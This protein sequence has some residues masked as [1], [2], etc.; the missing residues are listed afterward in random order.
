[1][2]EAPVVAV[3]LADLS[4]DEYFGTTDVDL[5]GTFT[6]P[7]AGDVLTLSAV[8]G[9]PAVVTVSVTGATLTVTEVGLG[10]SSIIVTATDI[11]GLSIA[12]TFDIVVNNVNDAPVVAAQL[13]DLNLDEHFGT[14]D[15]DLTGV[16]SDQDTGDVLTL[17][18]VSGT[19]TVVTVSVTGTTLTVTEV[20]LGTSSIIVTATDIDGLSIADTF[21]ITVNNVNDAPVILVPLADHILDE[22]FGFITVDLAGT[23]SD[24]DAGDVLTLSAVSGNTSVVTVSLSGVIL[25]VTEA[26]LGSATITVTASDGTLEVFDQ[27]VV[28]VNNVNDSPVVSSP[29]D[30]QSL[31]EYFGSAT[32]DVSGVFVDPDIVDILSLS[33]SC[34]DTDVVDVSLDGNILTISEVGLG[35]ATITLTASDGA[36]S[37]DDLFDVTVYNVNDAPV[38]AGILSDIT[39]DQGFVSTTVDLTGIFTDKDGDELSIS[40]ESSNTDVVTVTVDGTILSI[41]EVSVGNSTITVSANDGLLG[42]STSFEITV[43]VSLPIDWAYAPANYS[44]NGQITAA[45]EINGTRVNSGYLAAFV[46]EECRGYV[47]ASYF[48]PADHYVFDLLCFSNASSDEYLHFRYYDYMTM[49]TYELYDTIQFTPDMITGNAITPEILHFYVPYT[50]TFTTGWN[51]FSIN[52]IRE[53]MSLAAIMPACVT[54]GDNIKNQTSTATYYEGYGWFGSLTELK[55]K[56]LYK[57]YIHTGCDISTAGNTVDLS[58]TE[59]PLVGG[60]NWIGYLPQS[61]MPI[62][63]ALGSLTLTQLDY[64]KSQ[65]STATYYNGFGWFGS[66]LTMDPGEGYMLKLANPDTLIYP[67]AASKKAQID[68]GTRAGDMP[69]PHNFEF[70][71]TVTA[72]VLMEGLDAGSEENILYAYVG[73]E[74]RGMAEGLY[75]EPTGEFL[76]TL[77]IYSNISEGEEITFRFYDGVKGELHSCFEKLVFSSDMV[78]ADAYNTF[79]VN[80]GDPLGLETDNIDGLSLS[81]YP[82]PSE[83]RVWIDFS[84]PSETAVTI[85]IYDITGKMLEVLE[86]GVYTKGHYQL[87]WDAEKYP[88]GS[89]IVRSIFKDEQI[90]KRVT[91]IE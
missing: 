19:P 18:A 76:Y 17:S 64:I 2:N 25:T 79:I 44:F 85:M 1:V 47:E 67:L 43:N 15:V 70:S 56:D 45:V 48:S 26:G 21:D 66:L 35:T 61:S 84:V 40:A 12:D 8:S 78:V 24:P 80:L 75:F 81:A 23:F 69:D 9:A 11:D 39:I 86:K 30:N 41:N 83:G 71:G 22:H 6:D 16:F 90:T 36:L 77:M 42:V 60:W 7:D 62:S 52:V 82:N 14:T 63:D 73:E 74:C 54:Q 88:V 28:T 53:D 3:P 34:S 89:Y 57:T 27:F 55:P 87:E 5:T 68:S 29:I 91:L 20:G 32:I 50:T 38:V 31:N 59:I 58:T 13:S 51:W 72:K 65:T 49:T 46:G 4:L 33:V 37:V 10:S